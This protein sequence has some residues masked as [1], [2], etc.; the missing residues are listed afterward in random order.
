MV[1]S[2]SV[3][4]IARPWPT[5]PATAV[6]DLLGDPV[7]LPDDLLDGEPADDEPKVAGEDAPDQV[8]HATL[9]GE[10]P[11]GRVGDRGRVVADLERRR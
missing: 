10:E 9:L 3:S 2:F 7:P 4:R 8:F 1:E 11:A 6:L 5:S